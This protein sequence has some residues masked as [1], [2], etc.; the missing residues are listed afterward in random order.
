VISEVASALAHTVGEL[1]WARLFIGA[2]VGTIGVTVQGGFNGF[3]AL[4][5]RLYPTE[6]RN[7]GVGWA[8]GVGRIGAILGPIAGGMLVGAHISLP[9]IFALF[10]L[11]LV[12]AAAMTLCIRVR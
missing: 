10:A 3:W 5:A 2:G 7:T 12:A 6:M 8:L 11:P 1:M 9:I 4:A